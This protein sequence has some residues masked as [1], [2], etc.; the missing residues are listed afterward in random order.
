M[1]TEQNLKPCPFCGGKA[2]ISR[3]LSDHTRYQ[4][5]HTCTDR[6]P[7]IEFFHYYFNTP[8]EAKEF[9]NKR[10]DEQK[11]KELQAHNENLKKENK[12]LRERLAEEMEHKEDCFFS[13][14]LDIKALK[15]DTVK[16][17][18]ERLYRELAFLGAKDKFNKEY[19]LTEVDRVA[20][21]ILE[22]KE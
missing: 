3:A 22:G 20:K 6:H 18:R 11:I 16:K 9:W 21:E 12:Y 7:H 17:M 19:F 5:T 15:A 1:N 14:D 2:K 10:A 8:Q 4:L 13:V